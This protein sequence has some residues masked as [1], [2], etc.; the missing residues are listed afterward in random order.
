MGATI[1]V[2][3]LQKQ[4]ESYDFT[5]WRQ[6]GAKNALCDTEATERSSGVTLLNIATWHD[7]WYS[8]LN[9]AV[10]QLHQIIKELHLLNVKILTT[11]RWNFCSVV[12]VNYL[13]AF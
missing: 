9:A 6:Q 1:L 11:M 8:S 7:C 4:M 12:A 13:Q 2:H 3:R 5:A 10:S